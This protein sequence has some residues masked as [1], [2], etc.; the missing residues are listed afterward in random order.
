M[1]SC[2]FC[3][4]KRCEGCPVPFSEDLTYNDLLMKIGITSNSSFYNDGFK[5]GKQDVMFEVVWNSKIEKGFFDGFQTAKP[6]PVS[7]SSQST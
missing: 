6:F 4:D 5:R 1:E 2:H 7:S 3:Q